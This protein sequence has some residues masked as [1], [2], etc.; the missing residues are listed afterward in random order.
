VNDASTSPSS[1]IREVW[2]G[3]SFHTRTD[4][5]VAVLVLGAAV[6][7]IAYPVL[8]LQ[9]SFVLD[10][11]SRDFNPAVLVPVF[12]FLLGLRQLFSAVH[13]TLLGRR[14]GQSV[15]QVEGRGVAPGETLRGVIR[16]PVHFEPLGDYEI[17]LQCVQKVASTMGMT[18]RLRDGIVDEQTMHVSARQTDPRKGIPFAFRIPEGA[19]STTV[20]GTSVLELIGPPAG[21]EVRWILEVKAPLKGLNYYAIFGVH[22][23]PNSSRHAASA[24][25]TPPPL[26]LDRFEAR[27]QQLGPA[28]LGP[29]RMSLA[30]VDAI[31]VMVEFY[32]AERPDGYEG[33]GRDLLRFSWGIH[34]KEGVEDFQLAIARL[35][36]LDP[37][38]RDADHWELTLAFHYAPAEDLRA[39]GKGYDKCWGLDDVKR[40]EKSVRRSKAIKAVGSFAA[41]EVS[42]GYNS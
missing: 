30:P 32:R 34:E 15:M 4:W 17:R 13:G 8:H 31:A 37:N 19:L 5:I 36:S 35:L 42:L 11:Y 38:N 3:T 27:L 2:D 18:T 12:L 6:A 25:S 40:F 33:V 10:P 21:G 20:S 28:R 14:F 29:D 24:P 7:S 16:S 22:V 9:M 1:R 26:S 23:S 39:L 41:R